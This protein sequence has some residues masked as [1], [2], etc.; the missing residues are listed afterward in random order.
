MWGLYK[1]YL[2]YMLCVP[3]L[4]YL[5]NHPSAIGTCTRTR[6]EPWSDALFCKSYNYWRQAIPHCFRRCDRAIEGVLITT[7][8]LGHV[9]VLGTEACCHIRKCATWKRPGTLATR[10]RESI[11][12]SSI[13]VVVLHN[14]LMATVRATSHRKPLPTTCTT[15][16][17]NSKLVDTSF[18]IGN[19]LDNSSI[20]TSQVSDLT[21]E[22]EDWGTYLSTMKICC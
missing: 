13:I 22:D 19:S 5:V 16:R 6:T 11:V 9:S 12:F 4:M 8:H 17:R 20:T 21:K 15:R 2:R 7:G 18:A 3:I 1:L 14:Y 10:S